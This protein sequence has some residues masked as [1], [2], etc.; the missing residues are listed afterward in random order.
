MAPLAASPR[1]VVLTPDLLGRALVEASAAAVLHLWRD[2][3]VQP[4]TD[5]ALVIRYVKLLRAL[6]LAEDL[7]RRWGWWFTASARACY[8]PEVSGE[9][10]STVDLCDKVARRAGAE[11]V[12]HSGLITVPR[13]QWVAAPEFLRGIRS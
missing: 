12:V 4:A 7:I 9:A 6:G 3:A 2:G 11:C 8:F 1:K 13:P 10:A 5:G